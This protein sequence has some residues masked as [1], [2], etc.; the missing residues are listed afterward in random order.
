MI[1]KKRNGTELWYRAVAQ[2]P[3]VFAIAWLGPLFLIVLFLKRIHASTVMIFSVVVPS[4]LLGLM[5]LVRPEWAE[6][7]RR[8]SERESERTGEGLERRPPTGLP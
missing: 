3:A 8:V 6:R 4:V 2:N 7:M 1:E 5:I